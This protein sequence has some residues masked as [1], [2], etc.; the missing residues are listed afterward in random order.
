M[1]VLLAEDEIEIAKA[2]KI[3]L[4]SY[5]Y[6]VEIVHTGTEAW[7][8]IKVGC[9]DVIVLDIMMP[10]MDGIRVLEETRKALITTP[11]MLLTAKNQVEDRVH[12]LNV[13]ADDYLAK[14]F[15]SREFIARVKALSR[16]SVN[17]IPDLLC[18]GNTKL[19][20][21]SYE[22]SG[23]ENSLRLNRKEFQMMELFLRNPHIV[24]ST[25]QLLDKIWG[26]D[27]EAGMDVVWAYIAF[28]RKKLKQCGADVEIKTVRGA[29]YLLEE[30]PC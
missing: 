13:G 15:A 21:N 1:K 3:M 22:L 9:Y 30:K 2:L 12:G 18:F 19:D 17:Y 24:F 23:E 26:Y 7:D 14:P 10:G 6:T 11:V 29:G 8:Y 4:E 28:L 25:E 20:C 27:T 5:K 16:R